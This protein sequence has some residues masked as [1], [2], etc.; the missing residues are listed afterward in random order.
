LHDRQRNPKEGQD[1]GADEVGTNQQ[2]KA[3]HRNPQ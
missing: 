1:M 2:E 3:V